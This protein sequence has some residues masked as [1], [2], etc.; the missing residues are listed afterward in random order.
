[1]IDGELLEGTFSMKLDVLSCMHFIAEGWKL[2]ILTAIK[3]FCTVWFS[4]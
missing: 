4:D 2:V 1:M 3:N